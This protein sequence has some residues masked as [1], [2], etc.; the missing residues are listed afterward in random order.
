MKPRKQITEAKSGKKEAT[1]IKHAQS[2]TPVG[3]VS[4]APRLESVAKYSKHVKQVSM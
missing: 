4:T 3:F 2:Q 1:Y